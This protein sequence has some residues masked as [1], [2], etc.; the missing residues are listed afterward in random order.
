M[1]HVNAE[2]SPRGS[3]TG[4][5][6]ILDRDGVINRDSAAYIKS[7]AEWQALPGSLEAIASLCGSGYT[8]VVA[9]NQSGVGR[10]LL[11]LLDLENIHAKMCAE[12]EASG[13]R[14]AGIYFCPH[15][16]D[17]GCGC[18]KPETGMLQQIAAS[19]GGSL[20]GVPFIGDSLRDIQAARRMGCRPLLVLTGDGR[21]T[22]AA[23][24]DEPSD[25]EVFP[26][27]ASAAKTL[28]SEES[29]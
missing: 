22:L 10:G 7:P 2:T 18:R 1:S 5:L 27:L 12:I 29:G 26:D 28:C 3:R 24:G 23:L 9:T 21:Q 13:G 15:R 16:P 6:L 4:R 8:I 11:D 19:H 14:I 25:V 20:T 17:E